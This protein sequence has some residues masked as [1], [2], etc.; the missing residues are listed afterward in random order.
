MS[1]LTKK[2]EFWKQIESQIPS[3]LDKLFRFGYETLVGQEVVSTRANA[4][5]TNYGWA[6]AK[7]KMG[8]VC[9]NAKILTVFPQLVASLKLVTAH[10]CPV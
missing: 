5:L 10:A 7:S 6:T 4:R 9:T 2:Q 8:R 3:K 1:I